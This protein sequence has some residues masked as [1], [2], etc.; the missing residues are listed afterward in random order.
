MAINLI[1]ALVASFGVLV[2][3]LALISPRAVPL[4]GREYVEKRLGL[5]ERLEQK[6][7]QADIPVTPGEFLRVSGFLTA[8]MAIVGILLTN[9]PIGG[10]LGGA[11][12]A[13]LYWSYLGDRRDRNRAEYREAL[14]QVAALLAEGFEEGGS[15]QAAL[16]KVVEYGPSIVRDDFDSVLARLQGGMSLADA[17]K[18]I[19]DR[20]R[21]PV[22]DAICQMLVVRKQQGG[23]AK[24]ALRDLQALVGEQNR[25][26]QRVKA[27]M[28]QPLWEVRLLAVLPFLAVAFLRATTPEYPRF[29][30]TWIG[31]L[32]LAG[33]WGL[34][35][36]GYIVAMR[37]VTKA[38]A[39]EESLGVVEVKREAVPRG[40]GLG[41]GR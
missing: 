32:M 41:E 20:R 35:I 25:F 33:G 22:L 38:M 29:W 17:L 18:P 23:Q 5:M 2:I 16:Q 24:Q 39:V 1:L 21:D 6:L 3:V 11:I 13:L 15:E 14:E 36:I 7:I 9:A 27:E 4:K 30:S 40:P 31:Q 10:I 37:Y 26:R 12:G 28:G 8:L 34:T 19:Q